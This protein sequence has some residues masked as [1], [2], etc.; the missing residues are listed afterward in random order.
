MGRIPLATNQ[1]EELYL[2]RSGVW[3]T[4]RCGDR[5]MVYSLQ[6]RNLLVDVESAVYCEGEV[7]YAK[8]TYDNHMYAMPV[9]DLDALHEYAN[10]A[11][12]SALGTRTLS[13]EEMERYSFSGK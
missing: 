8:E 7:L 9:M 6:D 12:T 3:L 5:T 10:E 11:L 1:V 4:I 13:E 2:D